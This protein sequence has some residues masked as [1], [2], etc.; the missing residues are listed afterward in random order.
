MSTTRNVALSL[1]LVCGGCAG[2]R[3]SV[4]GRSRA[5]AE[6]AIRSRL[7]SQAACWNRGDIDGF[8]Q[9]YWRSDQLTFSSG[10]RTEHGWQATMDRYRRRYPTPDNMGRLTFGDLEVRMMAD[11][12]ALVLGRW[13]LTR[14][15]G[16]GGDA[17]GNFSL[18]MRRLNGD[19]LIVHDHTSSDAER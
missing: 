15:A 3:G 10:G 8:M 11:D 12:A 17:G 7:Q 1:V 9:T 18:V 14:S 4:D 19:W 2:G 6:A 13:E 5:G 16:A